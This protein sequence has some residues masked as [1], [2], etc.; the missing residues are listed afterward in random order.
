MINPSLHV[1]KSLRHQVET[2]M[3]TTFGELTQYFI[4]STF[5]K[6]NTSVFE[7]ITFHET[8]SENPKKNFR[9]LSCAIYTTIK[10]YVCID[11]LSC[12]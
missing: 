9:V 11:Y 12:Q 4:K 1:N 7:L 6:N 3:N 10:N 2:F 5:S 8:R